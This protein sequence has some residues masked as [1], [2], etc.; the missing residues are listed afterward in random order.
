MDKTKQLGEQAIGKLLATYSIPAVIAMLVNAIYN[1]VDRIFI[2]QYAGE[3]A[4]AGL[5]VVFP[6]MMLIFAFASLIGA[7]GASLMSIRLGEQDKEGANHVFGNTFSFGLIITAI[8][9]ITLSINLDGVLSLF[10][11][12]PE[13]MGE[14]V[15]YL[16]II[17]G[18]FIFQMVSFS[19]N[20]AVRTEG[21]PVLAMASM[22]ASA[23]TNI[24]LDYIFIVQLGMGVAGAAYAT[25]IGQFAGLAILT[26]HFLRG[27][28][29][30]SLQWK[31]MIPNL[32]IISQIISIGF[33]TFISTIG[34][35]IAMIFVNRSLG[36]YG[37]LAA[38]TSM[39]AINSLYTFF[40]MPIMGITQGMQPII[41]YN[42]GAK[43]KNRVIKTL[44]YG[45][46]IGIA[47][48]TIV[49]V[50]L[51]F[52]PQVFVG[53]FLE[54][55]SSTMAVAINGLKIYILMLPLL[56]INLMGIT[57]F[58]SIAKGTTS[59][60]LGLLRQLI[61]LVPLILV[62]PQFMGL[63]GVWLAIPIADALAIIITGA[64]L[65][66]DVRKDNGPTN[67]AVSSV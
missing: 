44:Q 47:F 11:A 30:F 14:A 32:K 59:M 24:V 22:L 6:V 13:V 21:Q 15:T 2:G 35:S 54:N 65:F 51:E 64:V 31:N 29:Q 55:G 40:I 63:N 41:G 1:V 23:L 46:V 48:S 39:G 12:T 10:G 9:L 67:L 58:Q 43:Q 61:F 53:M 52:F 37:G 5:T 57:Y 7:G 66:A 38:I 17:L 49:F 62:L 36:L 27:K 20:S 4:L 8:T 3:T 50:A 42:H 56:S 45:L 28:S 33:A 60:I 25:I 19:L 34:T 26:S 18:G 16:R